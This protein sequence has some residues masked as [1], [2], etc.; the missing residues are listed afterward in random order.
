MPKATQNADMKKKEFDYFYTL[1]LN[2][3]VIIIVSIA[4]ALVASA[5]FLLRPGIYSAKSSFSISLNS[6][7]N[8]PYGLYN[9]K[10]IDP[11]HYLN[12]LEARSEEHT[13]EL[14]S[15]PHL[16]CRLLLEKKNK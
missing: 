10:T 1:L 8:T 5:Y 14:Q 13:S 11:T 4:F 16:V 6:K 15:R 2:R 3:K 7:I 12:V 9:L